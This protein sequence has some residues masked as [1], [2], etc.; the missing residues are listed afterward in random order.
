MAP[1]K[2]LLVAARR[3]PTVISRSVCHRW[4]YGSSRE[5][6]DL[7]LIDCLACPSYTS[8]VRAYTYRRTSGE[9]RPQRYVSRYRVRSIRL[10][11]SLGVL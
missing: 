4:L 3:Y 7:K 2:A 1:G 6:D 5:R 8:L 9:S 11:F 10:S